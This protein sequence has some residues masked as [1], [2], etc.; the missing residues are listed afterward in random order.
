MNET[1]E[2]KCVGKEKKTKKFDLFTLS[3][4]ILMIHMEFHG[5]WQS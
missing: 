5:Y 2:N 3:T 4:M 1:V